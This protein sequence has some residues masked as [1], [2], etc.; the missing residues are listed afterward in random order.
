MSKELEERL[1]HLLTQ[2]ENH[3]TRWARVEAHPA[4][5]RFARQQPA[6]R[7]SIVRAH[8]MFAEFRKAV[9]ADHP[10][11]PEYLDALEESVHYLSRDMDG[12]YRALGLAAPT[13]RVLN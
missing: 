5:G 10:K 6:L 12:L 13:V 4:Y 11:L 7:Q 3:E 1:Q 2:I 9:E 8:K